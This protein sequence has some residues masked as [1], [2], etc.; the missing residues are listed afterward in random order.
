MLRSLADALLPGSGLL[1]DG[2]IGAGLALLA[3]TALAAAA[4]ALAGELVEPD[5]AA[6]LRLA[7]LAAWAGGGLAAVLLR[8]RR[9]RRQRIDPVL[10]RRL[11]REACRAWLRGEAD[12]LA[13]ARA[14]ARAAPEEAGAWTF[15][16]QVAEGGGAPALAA[17]ARR[18]AGTLA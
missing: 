12:A 5:A 1:R 10:V 3:A 11:H 14:L 2:R 8:W 16:A 6:V 13:R 9:H 15:L 7:A 17:R 4:A 18:R